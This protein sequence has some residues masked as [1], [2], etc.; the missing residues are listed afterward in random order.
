MDTSHAIKVISILLTVSCMEEYLQ[1]EVEEDLDKLGF[2]T[3]VHGKNLSVSDASR[4]AMDRKLWK[5]IITNMRVHLRPI[6]YGH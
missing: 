1:K 2:A 6:G 4:K 5:S 3:L